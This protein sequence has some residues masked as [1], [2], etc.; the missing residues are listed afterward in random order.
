MHGAMVRSKDG[1]M[2]ESSAD[3]W[4]GVAM[5]DRPLFMFSNPFETTAGSAA[6]TSQRAHR[7]RRH[8]FESVALRIGMHSGIAG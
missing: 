3:S 8:P 1:E 7:V 5:H 2:A 6:S 4:T